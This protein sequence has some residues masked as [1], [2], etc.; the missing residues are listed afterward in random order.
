MWCDILIWLAMRKMDF[1]HSKP[2]RAHRA[3]MNTRDWRWM[4]YA[5]Q[6]QHWTLKWTLI[7]KEICILACNRDCLWIWHL[8]TKPKQKKKTNTHFTRK[9]SSKLYLIEI[10]ATRQR[11]NTKH[12]TSA[13]NHK[14][15]GKAN[16]ISLSS[17]T[18][19]NAIDYKAKRI[20]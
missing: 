15:N 1:I 10:Y 8:A 5:Y 20:K 3:I 17:P 2:N 11:L 16:Q 7:V 12:Q 13:A 4:V 18:E 19:S 9:R 6:S 14:Q